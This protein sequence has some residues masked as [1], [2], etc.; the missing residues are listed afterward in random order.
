MDD[1]DP[2]GWQGLDG[3]LVVILFLACMVALSTYEEWRKDD[4]N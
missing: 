3:A 2:R 1:K 4:E